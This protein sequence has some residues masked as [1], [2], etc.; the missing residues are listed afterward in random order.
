MQ[1]LATELLVDVHGVGYIVTASARAMSRAAAVGSD[2]ELVIYTDVKE[3][4]ISLFGFAD[5]LEREVFMLLKKVKGIGPKYG[6]AIVSSLGPEGVLSAI[7]RG[8]VARLK[9]VPGVGKKTAERV[10]VEL[11]EYVGDLARESADRT[12]LAVER[13]RDDTTAREP[14]GGT[15]SDAVLALEKLGFA[16]DRARKAVEAAVRE[17]VAVHDAGELL[18][19]SFAHLS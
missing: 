15:E 18:R 5:Q 13:L 2:I 17:N 10:L 9:E 12:I 11:R 1:K 14:L 19:L 8:E 7:G 3:N 4:A 6:M 16:R